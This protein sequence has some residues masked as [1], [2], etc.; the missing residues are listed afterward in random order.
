MKYYTKGK[1]FSDKIHRYVKEYQ[2]N[3]STFHLT[4]INSLRYDSIVFS[5]QRFCFIYYAVV[6][7]GVIP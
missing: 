7:L 5:H 2:C 6:L 4:V 1:K 3:T